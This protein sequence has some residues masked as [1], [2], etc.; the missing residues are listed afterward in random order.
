M[1]SRLVA[2][3]AVAAVLACAQPVFADDASNF[4][5]DAAHDGQI[6]FNKDFHA[7]LKERWVIDLGGRVSFPVYGDGM[8][9]AAAEEFGATFIF[10]LDAKTGAI[11]WEK[12]TEQG[13]GVSYAGGK[14]FMA[15]QS[16]V[17]VAFDAKT[18]TQLWFVQETGES[19]YSPILT[20]SDGNLY[21]VGLGND[22]ALYGIK[23]K[24][25]KLHFTAHAPGSG[26][27][28][29]VGGGNVYDSFECLDAGFDAAKGTSQWQYA[30]D[31]CQT[32]PLQPP[33]YF[34]GNLY[35]NDG[36]DQA[37]LDAMTGA[38]VRPFVQEEFVPAF[39]TPSS[40]DALGFV[41]DSTGTMTAFDT[42]TGATAWSVAPAGFSSPPLVVNDT[43]F[44]GDN[45]GNLHAFDAASGTALWS[46]SAGTQIGGTFTLLSGLGAGGNTLFV[47]A[48]TT[49]S[50]WVSRK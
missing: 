43:V 28:P 33:V 39:W 9:F 25:G 5:I 35:V 42:M 15:D 29:A 36:S 38:L 2:A 21:Y 45:S 1:K 31:G 13:G 22:T 26:D 6:R 14:V 16:G 8:V 10:A 34:G 24:Q 12:E 19:G 49:I 50:A 11:K 46:A 40:G 17:I 3:A 48:G 23:Q 27:L 20:A 37:V 7:P 18:G 4:Q 44:I 41:V 32:G 47:P 30:P